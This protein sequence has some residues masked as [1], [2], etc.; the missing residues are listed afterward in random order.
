MATLRGQLIHKHLDS[1]AYSD[2]AGGGYLEMIGKAMEDYAII[3][4][5][6]MLEKFINI[7]LKNSLT[8]E[9]LKIM[10]DIENKMDVEDIVKCEECLD[11]DDIL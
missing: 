4:K 1:W 7:S 3:R 2:C 10:L 9:F 11:D 8:T 6:E 5:K